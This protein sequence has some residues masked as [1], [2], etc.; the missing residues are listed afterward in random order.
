M[1]LNDIAQKAAFVAEHFEASEVEALVNKIHSAVEEDKELTASLAYN[2]LLDL[3]ETT[4]EEISS[5]ASAAVGEQDNYDDLEEQRWLERRWAGLLDWTPPKP[6]F[7][8]TPKIPDWAPGDRVR[9]PEP[10]DPGG[11]GVKPEPWRWRVFDSEDNYDDLEEQTLPPSTAGGK[12]KLPDWEIR[13]EYEIVT[14]GPVSIHGVGGYAG[15]GGGGGT[16]KDWKWKTIKI[17]GGETFKVPQSK[18]YD[19][20]GGPGGPFIGVKVKYRLW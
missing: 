10:P 5:M 18:P 14:I 4:D 19:W 2:E 11:W 20:K 6:P 8:P 7:M 9:L 3:I 17:P 15:G 13:G 1:Q 16:G 12:F